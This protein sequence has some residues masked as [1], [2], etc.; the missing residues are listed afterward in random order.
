MDV[1][2][3]LFFGGA[4]VFKFKK[5]SGVLALSSADELIVVFKNHF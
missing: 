2:P 4:V 5:S 3:T 1:N